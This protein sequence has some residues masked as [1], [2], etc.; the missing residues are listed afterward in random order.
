MLSTEFVPSF[1]ESLGVKE[2]RDVSDYYVTA[3]DAQGGLVYLLSKQ[4]SSIL[5]LDPR[6]RKIAEVYS[7]EGVSDAHTIVIKEGKFYVASRES[8]ANKIF[9]FEK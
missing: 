7:F 4:Y 3:M 6:T 2:G 5:K 9:I 8:G 1:D